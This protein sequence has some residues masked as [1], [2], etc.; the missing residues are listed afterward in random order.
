MKLI[1]NKEKAVIHVA[2]AKL[3]MNDDDYRAMLAGFGVKSSKE[4]TYPQYSKVLEHLKSLGFEVRSGKAHDI[5]PV[6]KCPESRARLLGKIDAMLK[7]S[8]LPW[9]YADAISK[10]MFGVAMCRWCMPDQLRRIVAALSIYRKRKDRNG[11]GD[12]KA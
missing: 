12:G 11:R 2:K 10:K 6:R 8:G 5:Q 4:L 7:D 9:G 3:G 1:G